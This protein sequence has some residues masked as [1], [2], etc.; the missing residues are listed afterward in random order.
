MNV[1]S[2]STTP[3]PPAKAQTVAEI[4]EEARNGVPY[5]GRLPVIFCANDTRNSS[6]EIIEGIKVGVEVMLATF[7][8]YGTLTKPWLQ[9]IVDVN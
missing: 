6:P 8:P 1:L 9:Y 5:A 3:D 4:E 7:I 2:I